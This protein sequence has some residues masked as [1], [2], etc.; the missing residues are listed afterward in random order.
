MY[1][2]VLIMVLVRCTR[3][4]QTWTN[5]PAVHAP[6]VATVRTNSTDSPANVLLAMMV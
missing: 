3:L 2:G 5:V 4:F 6:M 1:Q